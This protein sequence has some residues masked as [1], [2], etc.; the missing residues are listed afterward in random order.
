[1]PTITFAGL[2]ITGDMSVDGFA[3]ARLMG[4]YDGAP[5]RSVV[6]ERPQSDGAFGVS[7]YYRGARVITV[8][9]EWVGST[10]ADAYAARDTL[11]GVQADGLP[12]TFTVTDEL[13]ARSCEVTLEKSPVIDDVLR[14]P[15]FAWSFDVVARD[16]RKY[17]A[18]VTASTG[19]PTSGTGYTWPATW[20]A[21]WGS[22]GSP[23]RVTL[24]NTGTS[25]TSPTLEVSGGLGG[26]VE[27]V[28]ITTGS[29]LRLEREIP[30][31]STVFFDTRTA[32]VYLDI[33][34]NDISS[35]LTRRDWA[36]F[37]VPGGASRT[38]QFNPLGAVSGTPVL[39]A[40]Y[41]PAY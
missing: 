1:M 24:T 30:T 6:R 15:F 23:G 20:P 25:D 28:E 18:E 19:V 8:E 9:G 11:A 26:G 33:P 38:V 37:T 34:A 10:M 12:S 13:G 41:A 21:T 22:G 5:S 3:V 40:R 7:R 4:W 17:G 31:S 27:L 36:G 29:Y 16:P 39:T 32:R 2:T 14:A 35:F